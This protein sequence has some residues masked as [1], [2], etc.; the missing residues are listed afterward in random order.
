MVAASVIRG[1]QFDAMRKNLKNIGYI[2]Q[3]TPLHDLTTYK[4]SG[5]GWTVLQVVCHL[6]DFEA[7]FLHRAHLTV[8]QD[9]PALPFPNPDELAAEKAYH[10]QDIHAVYA[11]WQ[12][13]RAEYIGYQEAL[14]EAAWER[15]A[16]HPTRGQVSL[17]DQLIVTAWHDVNH[18]EQI[19][20][21]LHE[22][23]A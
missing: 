10:K 14:P 3:D 22:K 9:V 4:D 17:Q 5:E 2:L 8:E 19:L 7:L 6:R 13:I 23:K 12:G 21:I 16:Q 20:R 1:W 11:D 15:L 18:L